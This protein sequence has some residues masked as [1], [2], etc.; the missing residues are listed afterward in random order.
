MAENKNLFAGLV[1]ISGNQWAAYESAKGTGKLIFAD[2]TDTANEGL[3]TGKYIYANGVEYK[4]ADATNLDDLIKRVNDVSQY[5][6]NV[7]SALNDLSTFI[8]T[9]VSDLS[10]HVRTVT[11]ASVTT[12]ESWRSTHADPSLNAFD[13]SLIDHETRIKNLEDASSKQGEAID[14]LSTYVHVNVDSSI[15]D[16]S[17]RISEIAITASDNSIYVNGT[18]IA[19][20]GDSYVNLTTAGNKLSAA[21]KDSALTKGSVHTTDVSLATKGYVDDQIAVLEQA[22]VFKGEITAADASTILTD[23]ATQAGWTYVAT[24]TAFDYNGKHIEA[25]DLV[26]V[27]TDAAAG[28]VSDII[29]V[30]RNLDGAVTAAAAL[31]NDYVILGSGNQTVKASTIEVNALLTA[32]ANANSAVQGV[33]AN[34]STTNFID[35][36]AAINSSIVTVTV[37]AKTHDVSTASA[38]SDG[39]AT[40]ISAK[41]Y[42]DAQIGAHKVDT[43]TLSPDSSYVTT[44][45]TVSADGQTI[46]ASVG[47]ITATLADASNGSTGLAMAEDVH[48]ELVAVEQ[49]IAATET[50]IA[51]SVGLDNNFGPG[52]STAS[53]ISSTASHRE[54]IEEL[55][56]QVAGHVVNSFDG[57]TG[58]I[59]IDKTTATDGSLNFTTDGSTLKGTVVGWNTLVQ[60]VADVSQHA[61]DNDASIAR[62]NSSV[63][64][65]ENWVANTSLV[66]TIAA[67]AAIAGATSSYV[68]VKADASK[69]DVTL[70]SEVLLAEYTRQ[71]GTA[72]TASGLATD[73]LVQ[74][75][76]ADQLAWAVITD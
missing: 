64:T 48:A 37:G 70:S 7:S 31:D 39:L 23:G 50:T 34:S 33:I 19:V 44:S 38:E 59:S 20:E 47:V 1:K 8:R 3:H 12:L 55:Y 9:E 30:E 51:E 75:Y 25:G 54:V 68:A 56:T 5:A 43:V 53:G 52:W 67:E 16:L 63:N 65:L 18:S 22:L 61:I 4:V 29:V 36:S 10:T 32:I 69:G 24:G 60:R 66:N 2:I 21:I 76:V 74:D 14:D 26:I 15:S 57:K 28:V 35:A 71:T 62:L 45:A 49:V 17:T 6:I 73:A 11:D 42:V 58:A 27:K 46:S 41:E 40:A 72:A 13:A